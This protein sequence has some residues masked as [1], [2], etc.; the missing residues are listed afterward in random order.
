MKPS[1]LSRNSARR[2]G[3]HRAIVAW[4][5]DNEYGCHDTVRSYS[6]AAETAFRKWLE[7]R[8]RSID[9]LNDAWGAVFWSQRYRHFAEVDMP[10][11]AVTEVNPSHA[12][13]F[14]RFSSDQVIDY[15][16]LQSDILRAYSPG[17]DIIHNFMG[18][19]T[20]FNHFA[21]AADIDVAGWDSYPLGF[22]DV[23]PFPQAEKKRLMRTGHPDFAAFHHDLYRGV[24]NGRFCVMEQQPGPVNWADHNPAPAPGAVRLWTHE[25]FAH[26]AEGVSYFRWRQAPFAQEQNH[27]GLLRPDD[28]ETPACDEIRRVGQEL[29]ETTGVAAPAT[30]ALIFAYEAQWLAEIQPQGKSW[31]YRQIAFEWYA[32][33]RRAGL[34]IDLV[35]PGR[36]ISGYKLVVAP[37]LPIVSDAAMRAFEGTDAQIVFG[38]RSGSRDVSGRIP[39]NLAPGRLQRFLPGRVARSETFPPFHVERGKMNSVDIAGRL[40][41]D[42]FETDLAPIAAAANGAGFAYR[43]D[44]FWLLTTHPDESFFVALLS[45]LFEAAGVVAAFC[46]ND[47]RVRANGDDLYAMNYGPD[48]AA[49]PTS[50]T[51]G[52][53]PAFGGRTLAPVDVARWRKPRS[54]TAS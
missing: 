16:R 53:S 40:H 50:L 42:H 54:E 20:D 41:L 51:D 52:A 15:N 34:S 48:D 13:D 23:A 39:D 35:P 38:P 33:L 47:L 17:R 45:Q 46:P 9:E 31:S 8:Y 3:R 19:F 1:A 7:G 11:A 29:P 37:S 5:T 4:Q 2:Y 36:D 25:A 44:R 32:A 49:P 43:R 28:A 26:G 14:Y 27:A 18:F 22:L 21:M 24:G 10:T 12:L 6:P 30:V